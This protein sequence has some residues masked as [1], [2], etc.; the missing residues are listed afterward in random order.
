MKGMCH[1]EGSHMT[2]KSLV[3]PYNTPRSGVTS[4]GVSKTSPD[5][6][7]RVNCHSLVQP[8]PLHL[9][10]KARAQQSLAQWDTHPP[11]AGPAGSCPS[12]IALIAVGRSLKVSLQEM[13]L[14]YLLLQVVSCYSSLS[15]SCAIRP[16]VHRSSFSIPNHPRPIDTRNLVITITTCYHNNKS[17]LQVLGFE[18]QS[19]NPLNSSTNPTVMH[20]NWTPKNKLNFGSK[21]VKS[22]WR[23]TNLLHI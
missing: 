17:N 23:I 13:L 10:L 18:K 16:Q 15:L 8:L 5:C 3:W 14:F 1:T 7:H 12:R 19:S 11:R 2:I 20:W 22:T 6:S 4:A 21:R 9:V